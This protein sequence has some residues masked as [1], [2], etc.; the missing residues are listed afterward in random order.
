MLKLA[1]NTVIL[2]LL[3]AAST[4]IVASC[5]GREAGSRLT[6]LAEQ[7]VYVE[8]APPPANEADYPKI[9]D[10]KAPAENA[11]VAIALDS[12][13]QTIEGFG[14]AAAWYEELAVGQ[15]PKGMYELMFPELGIDII[16]FRNRYNRKDYHDGHM[17]WD[18]E[19][20][21]R[22]SEALGRPLKAMIAAWS[23]PA[24][25]KANGEEKCKNNDDC[26]LAKE[27]GQFV[28]EK[29]A[30]FWVESLKHYADLGV[31]P[32]YVSIQNEPDFIPPDWEGCKFTPTETTKYPGYDKALVAVAAK[33][34][35][36]HITTKLLGPEVLGI[37]NHRMQD[38]LNPTIHNLVY[39]VEHHIYEKGDD[40]VWDWR[41]P[42]P[43]SFLDEMQSVAAL[44]TKPLFQT[45]FGTDE[46]KGIDG[47]F[48]T[49]WLMHHSLVT[50][51][52][53]SFVYW[54]LFWPGKGLVSMQGKS[55]SP[56]DQYYSTRHFA[57]YT[58]P[59]Y[60]RVGARSDTNSVLASAYIAPDSKRLTVVLLN[61]AKNTMNVKLDA[62]KFG[63]T[64]LSAYRT[65]YRPGHSKRWESLVGFSSTTPIEMPA[66]SVVTAVLE[67]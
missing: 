26:T 9:V 38:Y 53:A 67:K 58:D 60:V 18:V 61:T 20:Y 34:K 39:G 41:D 15:V 28:Y 57:R 49:A 2:A 52:I 62:A 43:D 65:V 66:R 54:E 47:G 19:I 63:A 50:E 4:G 32:E 3:V 48:E 42:G 46:D 16:R 7:D 10:A 44:T 33:L 55:P 59:G 12:R 45:E 30:D 35:A 36:A 27:N 22:G 25:L 29:Y 56:R 8:Q 21:K 23:P 1:R 14:A 17:D 40:N 5:V 6:S 37:H 11:A 13:F 24:A 31:V 64:K 51:G